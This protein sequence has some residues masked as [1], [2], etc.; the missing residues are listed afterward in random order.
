MKRSVLTVAGIWLLAGAAL[1]GPQTGVDPAAAIDQEI[2]IRLADGFK[3][4]VFADNLGTARH[5]AVRADG[6]LY[7]ALRRHNG[8]GGLVALEDTDGDGV[9]DLIEPFYRTFRGTGIGFYKGF[10]YYSSSTEL[11]RVAF[12]GDELVPS[13]A[14]QLMITFPAQRRHSPK[15]F[16]F[17]GAGNIYVTVGAPSDACQRWAGS[18]G[19]RGRDP[20]PQLAQ[21]AGIYRFA[22]EK[23][24]QIHTRDAHR[25]STG[26]RNA[27]SL[28][29]NFT[30]GALYFAMHGRDRLSE[31]WP[32]IYTAAQGAVLPAEEFHR[33]ADGSNHGWPYS[34]WDQ[35]KGQRMLG[36][37]YGGDGVKTVVGKYKEPLLAFPGHWA[38][39]DL[40]FYTGDSFPQGFRDGAFI[41]FHGSWNRAPF[42]QAGYKVVFIPFK[43]GKPTSQHIVFA[44]GFPGQDP[45]M[46]PRDARFRP[47]GLAV[48]PDGALF[49]TDSAKGRVWRITYEGK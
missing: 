5:A 48:A 37:E 18:K 47:M 7:V 41:A 45:V 20:C 2:G 22:A 8:S 43:D 39:N 36:P 29:W 27:M 24:D 30:A 28:D 23:P 21:Q 13:G 49:I 11:F 6:V 34:Y 32:E 14:P 4:T 38:P 44:D 33:A 42:P 12:D 1:A 19:S 46:S 15:P 3:A 25:Y 17:D 16:T 31:L 35:I 9:A 10:L 40:L 26:I